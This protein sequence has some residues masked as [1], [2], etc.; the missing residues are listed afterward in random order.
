VLFRSL[1][2]PIQ[3]RLANE[4]GVSAAR[5]T[6]VSTIPSIVLLGYCAW[7]AASARLNVEASPNPTWL[8]LLT[9]FMMLDS[10]I[11]YYVFMTQSRAMGSLPGAVVYSMLSLIAP[12]KFPWPRERGA[13]VFMLA[14]EED[15]VRRDAVH[16]RAPL[17]TLLSP[18]E[19]ERLAQRYGFE[20][21]K[22]AYVPAIILLL[23]GLV[24]VIS[25]LPKVR[26]DGGISALLSLIVAGVLVLEQ[27]VRLFA[28][29]RGPAGSILA[30]LVRPFVRSYL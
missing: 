14:P 22:S 8:W 15:V 7:R 13:E 29:R 6:L 18:G 21:R 27:I 19:Q 5:M 26:G 28:L 10:A 3:N 20:Y 24:G 9:G 16:M 1:P 4:Y 25:S 23:G 17:F 11:R 12:N 30:P 2:E